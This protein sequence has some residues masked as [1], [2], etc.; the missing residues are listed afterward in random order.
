MSPD[1]IIAKAKNMD[2]LK[3]LLE[4]I[5]PKEVYCITKDNGTLTAWRRNA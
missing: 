1:R 3:A 2:D 5:N 4:K